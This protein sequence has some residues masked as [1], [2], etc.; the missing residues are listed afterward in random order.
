MGSPLLHSFMAHGNPLGEALL[1]ICLLL[2]SQAV[3]THNSWTIYALPIFTSPIP[4]S[5]LAHN[6]GLVHLNRFNCTVSSLS[7]KVL[8]ATLLSD[9]IKAFPKVKLK[10]CDTWFVSSL[11]VRS[12]CIWAW[13]MTD[14]NGAQLLEDHYAKPTMT[15]REQ[16]AKQV[17][18]QEQNSAAASANATEVSSWSC[19]PSKRMSHP[20]LTDD[21]VLKPTGNKH[22]LSKP[23]Y[24]SIWNKFTNIYQR[25]EW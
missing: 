22:L 2:P 23:H 12:K 21:S 10:A 1:I 25:I 14:R 19:A 8:L 20:S 6:S 24:G 7:P 11:A 17:L 3:S 13:H 16:L 15:R 5:R 18:C 4:P 9:G